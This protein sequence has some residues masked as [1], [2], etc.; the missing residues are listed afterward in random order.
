MDY[1]IPLLYQYR[2]FDNETET[3][4]S[5][6]EKLLIKNELYF[7]SPNN[8]N[9]PF[10]CWIA[11]IVS[12]NLIFEML[13]G[14]FDEIIIHILQLQHYHFPYYLSQCLR[15]EV[16]N[17]FYITCLSEIKNHPLMLAHYSNNH[18]G[19][20]IEYNFLTEKKVFEE[21]R[22]NISK[23]LQVNYFPLKEE[24]KIHYPIIKDL[25]E[26]QAAFDYML[27]T[28]PEDWC[29]EKEWRIIIDSRIHPNLNDEKGIS[30]KFPSIFINGVYLGAKITKENFDLMKEISQKANIPLYV[31]KFQEGTFEV[32]NIEI[33]K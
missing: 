31:S 23:F 17:R 14:D 15:D 3:N 28:K 33:K 30:I 29:Y 4:R 26:S 10:D 7:S 24:C 6:L 32:L 9:D 19:Y 5:R 2:S 20:F 11:P 18:S 8:F 12:N 13:N 21:W 22:K 16:R 1:Q 27:S 25:Q